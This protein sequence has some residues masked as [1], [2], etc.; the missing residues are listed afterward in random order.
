M[1]NLDIT[2]VTTAAPRLGQAL[3]VASVSVS[4]VMS[5]YLITFA[6]VIPFGSWLVVRWDERRVF[7]T[8]IAVFTAASLWCA[9]STSFWELVVARAAQGVGAALMVPVG[10]LAVLAH[11]AKT[12][13]MRLIA[14]VVWPALLAPVIAPLLGGAIVTVGSWRWLFLVNVPLGVVALA[15]AHR[16]MPRTRSSKLRVRLDWVGMVL[17][18]T[19]LGGLVYVGYL[20]STPDVAWSSVA[21]W[22]GLFCFVLAIAVVELLRSTRPFIDLRVLR[23]TTLRQSLI[24]FAVLALAVGSVPMLLPLLFQDVFGWSPVL[25]GALV[26]CVFVGNLGAKPFTT[27]LLNRFGHRTIVIATTIGAAFTLL[28]LSRITA[29]MALAV[30]GTIA[31]VNGVTRSVGFTAL[32]TLIYADV[33]E[34]QMNH[35][36]TLAATVQQLFAGFAIAAGAVS[37]R[38]GS[39]IAGTS[40]ASTSGPFSYAFMMLSV[41]A[42]MATVGGFLMHP[43][44]GNAL[45]TSTR[46]LEGHDT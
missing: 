15:L 20:A 5:A 38:I 8:A 41:V 7:I 11:A 29:L 4:L 9:A 42:L 39:A 34:D 16:M 36:N 23:V 10:R 46:S 25:S 17:T 35:A 40:S 21:R 33:P 32:M 14:Y 45:R 2:I 22:G 43:T 27:G 12:D 6:V 31:F 24:G 26:A 44:A 13:V 30:I 37:L 1:E 3:G 18:C 28:A 19:S